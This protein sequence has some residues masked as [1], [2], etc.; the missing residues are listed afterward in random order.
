MFSIAVTTMS[1]PSNNHHFVNF[2]SSC[3]RLQ[4][5]IFETMLRIKKVDSSQKSVPE[6]P[7]NKF[8][9][10]C[11]E[12]IGQKKKKKKKKKEKSFGWPT[13]TAIC[14][15]D[16][17][18]GGSSDAGRR[19]RQGPVSVRLPLGSAAMS[20]TQYQPEGRH[21]AHQRFRTYLH[22]GRSFLSVMR[23]KL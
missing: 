5:F 17:K 22:A 12:E 10:E 9:P 15:T 2:T 11:R 14:L 21:W 7:L 16:R 8:T 6:V 13:T 19:R 1:L 23:T 20:T 4:R 18:T 3:V